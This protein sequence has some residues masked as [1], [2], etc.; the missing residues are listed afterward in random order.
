[1][2][3]AIGAAPLKVLRLEQWSKNLLVFVPL[4]CGH[5]FRDGEQWMRSAAAMLMFG[6]AASAQYVVN[7]LAD[8]NSDRGHP[9][10]NSRPIAAGTVSSTAAAGMAILLA[11]L[12]F[13]IAFV[14]PQATVSILVAYHGLALVYTFVLRKVAVADVLLLAALYT[15]RV[16]G[17]GA[18][19]SIDISPW[20]FALCLFLF[21]S[22]ALVKRYADLLLL[23]PDAIHQGRGYDH[24]DLSLLLVLG[25]SSACVSVLVLVLYLQSA[26]ASQ[27]YT[28]PDRLW[29]LCPLMLYWL[30][31]FWRLAQ[32]GELVRDPLSHALRDRVSYLVVVLGVAV[33][34][35]S[36]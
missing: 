27:I 28:Y 16:L 5:Q 10:K 12:S 1:M 11:L 25:I 15:L 23:G 31:R 9:H 8:R 20:L 22:L 17:G 19:T 2:I 13:A 7:D 26:V 29:L 4:I 33:F 18:A 36:I 30:V 32:R 34:A 3:G 35:A 6:F 14:L 24:R 21:L